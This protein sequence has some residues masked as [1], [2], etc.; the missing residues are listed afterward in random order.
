M[1]RKEKVLSYIRS[2]EY[3]PLKYEELMV[4]LDV[5]EDAKEEFSK[6]IKTLESEGKIIKSKKGRYL[7]C[8]DTMTGILLCAKNGK[9]GFVKSEDEG[10][11]DVYIDY[12][13]MAGALH[14]D[15]VLVKLLPGK[16][17]GESPEGKI[18]KVLERNQKTVVGVIE[19]AAHEIGRA[20]V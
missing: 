9:F 17:N 13:D 15:R 20:H 18:I 3:I 12:R 6:I 5:P 10:I 4:V 19:K 7:P 11:R 2:K 1:D 14:S 16:R 8:D